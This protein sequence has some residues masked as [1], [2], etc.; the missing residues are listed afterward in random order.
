M[1][2]DMMKWK[3]YTN[4]KLLDRFIKTVIQCGLVV[5]FLKSITKTIE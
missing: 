5:E 4:G 1:K 2:E 3:H